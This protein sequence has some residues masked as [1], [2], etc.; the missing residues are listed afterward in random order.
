MNGATDLCRVVYVFACA[1]DV[2]AMRLSG[3]SYQMVSNLW[4]APP[5]QGTAGAKDPKWCS[6]SNQP[7]VS[8]LANN[9]HN[10]T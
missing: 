8:G 3:A 9:M 6:N 1:E 2:W 4:R 10:H 5:P 7:P